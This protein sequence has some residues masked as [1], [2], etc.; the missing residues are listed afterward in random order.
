MSQFLSVF[1]G[2]WPGTA[3]SGHFD[4]QPKPGPW[5]RLFGGLGHRAGLPGGDQQLPGE[6]RNWE[7]WLPTNQVFWCEKNKPE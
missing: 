1:H 4:F 7:L 3:T 6:A 5:G 2:F